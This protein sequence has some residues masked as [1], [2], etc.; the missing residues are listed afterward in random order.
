MARL[1]FL[2][3]KPKFFRLQI[4]LQKVGFDYRS[5]QPTFCPTQPQKVVLPQSSPDQP[6]LHDLEDVRFAF[7]S[8][9]ADWRSPVRPRQQIRNSF[10]PVPTHLL[11]FMYTAMQDQLS[12]SCSEALAAIGRRPALAKVESSPLLNSLPDLIRP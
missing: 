12:T 10:S 8:L 4:G 11:S 2:Q 5:N 7:P 3:R 9:V 1:K 6:Q